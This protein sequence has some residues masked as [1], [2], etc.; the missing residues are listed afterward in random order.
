MN[1][2][3]LFDVPRIPIEW[4]SGG[5]TFG[6]Q[7]RG[8]SDE[9]LVSLMRDHREQLVRAFDT[10]QGAEERD[11]ESAKD[12]GVE[13]LQEVP[14]LV[15]QLIALAADKPDGAPVIRKMPA[16]IKLKALMEIWQL[17][18]VDTGG[19]EPFLTQVI[20]VMQG[21]SAGMTNLKDSMQETLTV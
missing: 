17:T 7:V 5:K 19:F 13:L 9:D 21:L 18:V 16:P 11:L 20:S 3:L 1:T 12:F 8:I 6:F 10:I 15:A 14:E 4:E 2:E